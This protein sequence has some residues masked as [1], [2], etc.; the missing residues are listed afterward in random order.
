M[1]KYIFLLGLICVVGC[2]GTSGPKTVNASG[3]VTLDGAP[4]EKAQVIFIQDGGS[5]PASAMTDASGKFSLS[6]NG[7]KKG[8]LP[9][10]YKAQVSKTILES[11]GGGGAEV[12]LTQGLPAK[13]ANIMTSGLTF[14]IP[15]SGTS[16]LKIELKK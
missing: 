12:K 7:E 15:A 9:G 13:Y 11:K 3:T 14:E 6:Y 2:E 10:S 8:A 1:S 4:V 5:N 16:D